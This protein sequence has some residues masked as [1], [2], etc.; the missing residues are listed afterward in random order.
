MTIAEKFA[1][2][3]MLPIPERI[4]LAK[5]I[6]DSI[7]V[8]SIPSELTD[9]QRQELERRLAD[10]QANPDDVVSWEEIKAGLQARRAKR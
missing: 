2:I 5:A 8:E 3:M 7:A 9:A 1:E 4:E 10:D 6:L